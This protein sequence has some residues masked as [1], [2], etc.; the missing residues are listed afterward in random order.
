ML[1]P[2]YSERLHIYKVPA[3]EVGLIQDTGFEPTEF[4]DFLNL[5]LRR[6]TNVVFSYQQ[7]DVLIGIFTNHCFLTLSDGY[8]ITAGDGENYWTACPE[9]DLCDA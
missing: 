3:D 7:P 8:P 2:D 4:S 1:L 5:F 6:F 9:V